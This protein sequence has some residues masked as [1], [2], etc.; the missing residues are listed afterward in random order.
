MIG[1]VEAKSHLIYYLEARRP[2]GHVVP[3][4]QRARQDGKMWCMDSRVVALADVDAPFI[5][6]WRALADRPGITPNPFAEVDFLRPAAAFQ[7]EAKGM[8]LFVGEDGGD[9]LWLMPLFPTSR[10]GGLRVLP[11]LRNF[12][13][14]NPLGQPLIVA[15][16]ESAAA[17]G[18]LRYLSDDRRAF[19]LRLMMLDADDQFARS[20][21]EGAGHAFVDVGARG[22]VVRRPE[23][24]YLSG[25]KNLKKDLGRQRRSFERSSGMALEVI[26][27]SAD[28]HAV[29]DF[30]AMEASG[31]KGR[32]DSAFAMRP[33]KA[34][35][36]KQMC[37]N[38]RDGGRLRLYALR[39]GD[40]NLA[41]K[42]ML[43]AND[44]L[45][46]FAIAFDERYGSLSPGLQLQVEGFQLFHDQPQF[47]M[48]DSCSDPGNAM[49]NRLFPDRR[50]LVNV[51]IGSGPLGR[52]I[53]GLAPAG[54]RL[55]GP[56]YPGV[57]R[58]GIGR[59]LE[60]LKAGSRKS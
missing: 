54:R 21:I 40:Q 7:P 57:A 59:V 18:V 55:M 11:G 35:F 12:F 2:L 4:G 13:E 9:L 56:S 53:V 44:T 48:M 51:T 58:S 52:A 25:R 31:W 10:M 17:S 50:S 20:L 33:G 37:G 38:F 8:R 36:L 24:T 14:S 26:D 6:R 49:A 3:R 47:R 5:D 23:P 29:D 60:R 1:M 39:A 15:G 45:F 34:E 16:Q 19:W 22:V 42:L 43:A 27:C 30:L 46:G 28:P 32:A 41:M